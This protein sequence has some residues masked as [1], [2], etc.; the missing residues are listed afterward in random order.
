MSALSATKGVLPRMSRRLTGRKYVSMSAGSDFL[1][2]LRK[3]INEEAGYLLF[4]AVL[5]LF[6]FA[7]LVALLR[8][9]LIH[10]WMRHRRRP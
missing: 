4:R 3:G 6:V 10:H 2:R 9:S 1:R 7:L 8:F 5:A